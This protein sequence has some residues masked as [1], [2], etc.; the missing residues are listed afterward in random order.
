MEKSFLNAKL[1]CKIGAIFNGDPEEYSGE[2]KEITEIDEKANT[3]TLLVNFN[4]MDLRVKVPYSSLGTDII[5]P[6]TGVKFFLKESNETSGHTSA[7]TKEKIRNTIKE[8]DEK[9]KI[10][11]EKLESCKEEDKQA[12]IDELITLYHTTN[13]FLRKIG[14]DESEMYDI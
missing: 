9:V 3:C 14:A 11:E 10:L 5:E 1:P 8:L 2:L 6:P 13:F 12:I 7:D 4:D